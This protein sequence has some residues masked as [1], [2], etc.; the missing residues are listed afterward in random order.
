MTL[1][2]AL[3]PN[4]D[5]SLICQELERVACVFGKDLL[6]CSQLKHQQKVYYARCMS[7]QHFLGFGVISLKSTLGSYR[8]K[9][10]ANSTRY[11]NKCAQY[12][13]EKVGMF[14]ELNDIS[15][16]NVEIVFEEGNFDYSALISL[17]SSCQ[18]NPIQPDTKFLS[19]IDAF[20]I[21]KKPKST[22]PL[23]QLADL[24]AHSLFKCVDKTDRNF[25]IPEPRYLNELHQKFFSHPNTGR[26]EGCGIKSVHDLNQL[27]L[28]P[29][30][31]KLLNGYSV[32]QSA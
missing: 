21:R 8:Q 23:L 29:D 6:H 11:Y 1:G 14:M 5:S 26:I 31:Q 18:D 9:I 28:D 7:N 2:A 30:I 10:E 13:L 25:H 24:V 15:P 3:V 12:L 27:S 32:E 16:G 17:I 22:E 20:K 19:R 4:R